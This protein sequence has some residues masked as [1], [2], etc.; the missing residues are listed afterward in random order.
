MDRVLDLFGQHHARYMFCCEHLESVHG[1]AE[2]S[3][4]DSNEACDQVL[5]RY[6]GV[7]VEVSWRW[8]EVAGIFV[9]N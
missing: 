8:S 1:G 7:W 6:N 2:A 9:E 4:L 5:E 3:A